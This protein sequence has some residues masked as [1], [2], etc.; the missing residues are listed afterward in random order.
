MKNWTYPEYSAI[1]GVALATIW[2]YWLVSNSYPYLIF[3][4]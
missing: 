3:W 2:I 1:V 4:R